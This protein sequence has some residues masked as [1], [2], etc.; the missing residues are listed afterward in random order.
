M[1]NSFLNFLG[2]GISK[3]D[4]E[5]GITIGRKSG[6][7]GII[8]NKQKVNAKCLNYDENW[9]QGININNENADLCILNVY[10]PYQSNENYDKYMDCL[11]RIEAIVQSLDVANVIIVGD[12]NANLTKDKDGKLSIFGENLL[13]FVSEGQYILTDYNR[14]PDNSFTYISYAWNTTSWLD[15]CVTTKAADK[16]IKEISILYDFIS[17]DHRPLAMTLDIN[18]LPST[19]NI[20]E[21]NRL[22]T[23][24]A[25]CTPDEIHSYKMRTK[26][27][28]GKVN[29]NRKFLHCLDYNCKSMNAQPLLNR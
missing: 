29:V 23:N 26:D 22:I 6:G 8:W 11:G 14:L 13:N 9:V 2:F 10:L 28:L 21:D 16:C 18:K 3:T 15:H 5:S 27:L 24:W 25:N 4:H 19:E 1:S 20:N 7:I 17:S 12:F